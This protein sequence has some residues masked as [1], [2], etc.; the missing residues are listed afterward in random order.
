MLLV[1]QSNSVIL[2]VLQKFAGN[3]TGFCKLVVGC[4]KTTD[5]LYSLPN[6]SYYCQ[7]ALH[8]HFATNKEL[9]ILCD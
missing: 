2:I 4:R 3:T 6:Y 9:L 8:L 7:R 5:M 1:F